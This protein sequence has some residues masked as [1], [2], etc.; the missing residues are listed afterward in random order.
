MANAKR[1]TKGTKTPK[2]YRPGVTLIL[3]VFMR[4]E[5]RCQYCL[6]AGVELAIDHIRP[7]TWFPKGTPAAVANAPQNLCCA[8]ARCNSRRKGGLDLESYA[9]KL[10]LCGRAADRVA[11]MVARVD[12]ARLRP[13]PE[14]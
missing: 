5:F 13:L 4:D 12:A 10:L 9:R 14:L 7:S 6:R 2:R 8:C 3:R 1:S 11:A